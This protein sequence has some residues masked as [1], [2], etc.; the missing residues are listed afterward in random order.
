MSFIQGVAASEGIAIAKAFRLEHNKLIIEKRHITNIENEI[1]KFQKAIMFAADELEQIR[2]H[3][4]AEAGE[5]HAAIFDAHLLVLTDPELIGPVK[6]KITTEKLNAEY[7]IKEI[8]NQYIVSLSNS[9]NEYMRERAADIR[10]VASRI[11]SHLLGIQVVNPSMIAEDVIIITQNLTPSD[12]AMLNPKVIKGVVTNVGGRTS[13]SAFIAKSM[14][15][16]AVV[17]T[18]TAFE[19]IENG[20]FVIL[21]GHKGLVHINPTPELIDEYEANRL[22]AEEEI[23]QLAW[24]TNEKTISNDGQDYTVVGNIGNV[25]EAN[26]VI[27]NGGEGI[28]LFRT[29]FLFMGRKQLPSEQEQFEAYKAVLQ[30]LNGKPVVVRTL[31]IGGDKELPYLKL[32]KEMN[33]FLGFRGIRFCLGEQSILR[34]Q[35]RALIRASAFGK[36]KIMF[37]MVAVIEEFRQGKA[38]FEE[39]KNKLIEEGVKVG[40]IGLGMMVEIP[41][42]ALM[43]ESFAKEVDFFSIGTNDLIQYTLAADRLNEQVSY[44]YQPYHPAILRLIQK[45]INAAHKEGKEVAICGDMAG[46]EVAIPL[47]VGMGLDEFSVHSSSI[48][49]TRAHIRQLSKKEIE[50]MLDDLLNLPNAVE[51]GDALEKFSFK[52]NI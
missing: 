5:D 13:H 31:D 11:Q 52:R 25:E 26:D 42:T 37:P 47:L 9:E 24:L 1:E 7:A 32:S 29:E 36:L 48:I 34:K 10:D 49:K 44:L 23:A 17:G 14:N 16:P 35:L 4:R 15:I 28:G 43:I 41:S 39:E 2:D 19:D 18:K 38:M 6:D 12:A 27:R 33:P 22:K 20:D 46:N 30:A 8:T 45:V 21:D 40:D 51:I 50:K 3:S